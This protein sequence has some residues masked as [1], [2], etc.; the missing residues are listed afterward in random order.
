MEN[1]EI[2]KLLGKGAYG[3]AVLCREMALDRLVV[4]KQVCSISDDVKHLEEAR[5]EA[6][7]LGQLDHPNVVSFYGSFVDQTPLEGSCL[8]IVMEYCDSGDLDAAIKRRKRLGKSF[9]ELHVMR[10]FV[11]LVLA[12][13][14]VHSLKILHRDIKPQ[15][16]FLT[17]DGC[18]KLGDF[19]VAKALNQTA[20]MAHTQLGTPYYLS[21]EIFNDENY[22]SASDIWSLGV[23]AYEL[24]TLTLPFQAGSLG[25]L[26]VRVMRD[27][28][29]IPTEC[30]PELQDLLRHLLAKK[31]EERPT[32]TAIL[33]LPFVRN[34]AKQLLEH[35][36]ATGMGGLE[37]DLDDVESTV[38]RSTRGSQIDSETQL[39]SPGITTVSQVSTKTPSK[40]PKSRL[41]LVLDDDDD[42]D[43]EPDDEDGQGK[44]VDE[45][46]SQDAGAADDS[47][48]RGD[49][50]ETQ[51]APPSA[52][53]QASNGSNPFSRAGNPRGRVLQHRPGLPT[54]AEE[55]NAAVAIQRSWRQASGRDVL[56]SEAQEETTAQEDEEET[57]SQA[58]PTPRIAQA[59][60]TSPPPR[61]RRPS[62]ASLQDKQKAT[63]AQT[64]TTKATRTKAKQSVRDSLAKAAERGAARKKK[65]EEKEKAQ[66]QKRAAERGEDHSA[67]PPTHHHD[68]R[69]SFDDE[70]RSGHYT[71]TGNATFFSSSEDPPKSRPTTTTTPLSGTSQTV[72]FS[73]F[74]SPRRD[75]DR[76]TAE[77]RV[78][79]QLT[80][81]AQRGITRKQNAEAN[82]AKNQ[83][84]LDNLYGLS[85]RN[86]KLEALSPGTTM[87]PRQRGQ[88]R[89]RQP[90]RVDEK[91]VPELETLAATLDPDGFTPAAG[92]QAGRA[93]SAARSARGLRSARKTPR[94]PRYKTKPSSM[95]LQQ[96]LASLLRDGIS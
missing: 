64:T 37:E 9:E 80:L 57:R 19:G 53:S 72:T 71:P 70:S 26:A 8:H 78:R 41:H 42:D 83:R 95:A 86:N 3:R 7:I 68:D 77:W 35:A 15:N 5:Q 29:P 16:A 27:D 49:D 89:N 1:Y 25:K 62:D 20:S 17:S 14:Y 91:W 21:P 2:I 55:T 24:T 54:F 10:I 69:A 52:R 79:E 33:K 90:R 12:L 65:A 18:V 45:D 92:G 81:A 88:R 82:A 36:E 51:S 85:S 63:L 28:P 39:S 87:T 50:E 96:N 73:D 56:P 47:F 46:A 59:H 31:A 6:E 60:A 66:R 76:P 30:S 23:L 22:D 11:Q 34:H 48:F 74:D 43:D 93:V 67:E 44:K 38:G 32:A 13:E 94:D 75:D 61:R 4:I 84:E 58:Q 40:T